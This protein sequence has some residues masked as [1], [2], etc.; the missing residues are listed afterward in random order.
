MRPHFQEITESI[1]S[2]KDHRDNSIRRLVIQILPVLATF[3]TPAFL[4]HLEVSIDFLQQ[5]MKV[6]TEVPTC[7][8]SFHILQVRSFLKLI[9]I[10]NSSASIWPYCYCGQRTDRTLSRVCLAVD[11]PPELNKKVNT[12]SSTLTS[13]SL[14]F[15]D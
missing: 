10:K 11:M 15:T 12:H 8:F 3:D 9:E 5:E 4:D 7:T 1:L 2:C 6:E 13:S 14:L